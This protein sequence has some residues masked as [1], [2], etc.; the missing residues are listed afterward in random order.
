MEKLGLLI[1]L[2]RSAFA[3]VRASLTL[4]R[5]LQVQ[6][7]FRLLLTHDS[8]QKTG[9]SGKF[10]FYVAAAIFIFFV[11]AAMSD[12][13]Q[14]ISGE[15]KIVPFDK[16]QT[17]QHFEGGIIKEIHVR[18]GQKVSVGM[19][20]LSLN[21]L[22]ASGGYQ[23]KKYDFMQAL[24]RIQ[25]LEA[26]HANKPPKFSPEIE[27]FSPALVQNENLLIVARNAKLQSTLAS[28]DSQLRQRQSELVGAKRTLA[29]VS[30]ERDVV[31]KLV[32]RGLE[33]KLEAVRAEKTLAESTARVESILGA[34]DEVRDRKAVALQEQRSEIL[35]ELAKAK[36]EFS[37]LE[38]AVMV[39]ADKADR[40]VLKSPIDG[41]VNRVLVSTVGGVLKA[42]EPA[43]EI[44]PG[45]SKLV[46]ETKVKPNDIGFVHVGQK[47]FIKLSTYDFSIFGSLN[48]RVE[49]V[50]ADSIPNE[51]GETYYLV[52]VELSDKAIT[53]TGLNLD[54]MSGMT[55]QVDIVTGKRSVLSYLSSPIT[56][57]LS[58][59][60]KEK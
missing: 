2:I 12:F 5:F 47:A 52:K 51:K 17:V 28:F 40:N 21:P 44:V 48:G 42:G 59:A 9:L 54:L 57:T 56:K 34:I 22:E 25:R 35:S 20:L 50:G 24:A 43:V 58:T 1:G 38:Q 29:L 19:P 33:P 13:D 45:D 30:E 53:S 11:W 41:V 10:L 49:V 32:E 31:K 26:E 8:K 6:Q 46:F 60:F 27:K 7:L 16:L 18:A 37:Q 39:A 4:G 23:A 36:S 3:S 55:A 14:V 15:A